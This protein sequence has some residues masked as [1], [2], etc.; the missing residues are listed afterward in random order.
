[1]SIDSVIVH[2][3]PIWR[4]RSNFI[5]TGELPVGDSPHDTEQLWARRVS[6]D[7]FEL[8]CIPF[9]LYD[10]ALGDVVATRPAGDRR[11]VLNRVI[12][13]SGRYVFRVWFGATPYPRDEIATDLEELGALLEWS[14]DNMVAVDAPSIARAQPIA[15]YLLDAQQNGRLMYETGK[16]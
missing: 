16:S 8:C 6:G 1:M 15:D 14:S 10:V 2:P 12:R 9:F 13:P 3:E 11:Y 5:I 7:T 4:D